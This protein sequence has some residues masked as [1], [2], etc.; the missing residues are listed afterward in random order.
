MIINWVRSGMP[1]DEL[2]LVKQTIVQAQTSMDALG[3]FLAGNNGQQKFYFH[4]Q[5]GQLNRRAIIENGE[6]D[7]W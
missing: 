7:Q 4:Y 5:A 6:D 2:P 1:N 3:V